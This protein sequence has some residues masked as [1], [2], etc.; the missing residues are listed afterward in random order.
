MKAKW[1]RIELRKVET[2]PGEGSGNVYYDYVGPSPVNLWSTSDEYGHLRSVRL[3]V[4]SKSFFAHT[5]SSKTFRSQSGYL[6]QYRPQLHLITEVCWQ[7]MYKA[8]FIHL[9]YLQPPL[10]TNC[11]LVSARKA[12]GDNPEH[13][14]SLDL[15]FHIISAGDFFVKQSLSLFR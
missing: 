8:V 10:V 14:V 2:L 12:K 7:F 6:N 11:W 13:P 1:V 3:C 4:N 15:F 5:V 9:L